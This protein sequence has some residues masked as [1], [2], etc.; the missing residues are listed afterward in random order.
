VPLGAPVSPNS[1]A[2]AQDVAGRTVL[3]DPDRQVLLFAGSPHAKATTIA[4]P[5]GDYDG[6]MSN[7][8]TVV[9]VNRQSGTVLTYGPDGTPQD[10]KPI[11]HGGGQ[12]PRLSRGEDNRIY[13]ENPN[14]T[15]VLVVGSNGKVQD[16]P[17]TPKPAAPTTTSA[18]S[19]SPSEPRPT[20]STDPTAPPSGTGEPVAPPTTRK[21]PVALPASAPGAPTNVSATAGDSSATVA[22]GAATD[23]RSAITSY[24]VSYQASTG[25]TGSVKMSGG[26]RQ[27]AVTGL[28]NGVRYVF[29]VTATNQVGTGPGVAT[30][31]VIPF[32]VAAAPAVTATPQSGGATVSWAAPDLRGGTLVDYQVSATGQADQSV[33]T[34]STSYTGFAPGQTVTFTVRAMTRTADGRSLTGAPGSYSLT[35]PQPKIVISHGAPT[36]SANCKVP[37][38]AQVDATM[39][40]FAPNQSYQITLASD[41]NNTVATESFTTDANGAGEHDQLDYDSPGQTVWVVVNGIKSNT[42]RWP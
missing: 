34:T 25:V 36:T 37:D 39:T 10:T 17:V 29:T 21:P 42:I 13:V 33:T 24:L 32:A 16:V 7:G 38:C 11:G 28:T 3:F 40:G 1:R 20:G 41:S 9:V 35:M 12:Q 2:A 27:V 14:G 18:G 4:L 5:G 30:A 23:N 8:S 22:W 31:P 19:T 6:P 26:A 15:H